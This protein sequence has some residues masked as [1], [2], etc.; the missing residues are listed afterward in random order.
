MPAAL[1]MLSRLDVKSMAHITGDGLT[2]LLRVDSELGFVIDDLP[3]PPPIFE[4]IQAAG[5]VPA[6]EMYEVFNMGIGFC[7]VVPAEQAEEAIAISPAQRH[8]GLEDRLCHRRVQQ[9]GAA[10]TAST[11][12]GEQPIQAG[13]MKMDFRLEEWLPPI[14]GAH[15]GIAIVGA[16]QVVNGAHL[17]AY[18]KGRLS[19]AGIF[20]RDRAK[21]EA[22]AGRFGVEKVYGSLEE[23]LDDPA[24]DIVDVAVPGVE[25]K[26]IALAAGRTGQASA[27]PEAVGGQR[28]RWPGDSGGGEGERRSVG[29]EH[30]R[31]LGS[32]VEV[33]KVPDRRRIP[34]SAALYP[35]RGQRRRLA[36]HRMD[37]RRPAHGDSI[38]H[39]PLHRRSALLL[40]RAGAGV[41][42]GHQLSGRGAAGRPDGDHHDGV[43]GASKGAGHPGLLQLGVAAEMVL[44][45]RGNG[46]SHRGRAGVAR[47]SQPASKHVE[48]RVSAVGLDLGGAEAGRM[49]AAGR[50]AGDDDGA[51]AGGGYGPAGAQQRGRQPEDAGAGVR[52]IR[53]DRSA[54]GGGAGRRSGSRAAEDQAARR[55]I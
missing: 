53:C 5:E 14:E 25:Q 50:V 10:H 19:V 11:D 30:E 32:G 18:R 34:G 55:E 31:A 4:L 21:A 27:V 6:H 28:R 35:L 26:T 43:S 2:N 42:D 38:Q 29:G 3:D 46:G 9:A 12:R 22:T 15:L 37:K 23:L 52:D 44:P 1:E 40:W 8:A 24:V 51:A 48:A 17:P 54:A 33:G 41:G 36:K 47:V 20:D 7:A 39:H 13:T 49:L 45:V 16:G